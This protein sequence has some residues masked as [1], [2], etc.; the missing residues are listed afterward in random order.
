[1]KKVHILTFHNALNYGGILQCYALYTTI[2]KYNFCDVIDYRS[3]AIED[4]YKVLRLGRTPKQFI[5][6]LILAN[7]TKAKRTKFNGFIHKNILTTKR[8][9]FLSELENYGWSSEDIF[10]V[11]SDQVWNWEITKDDLAFMCS[12][13]PKYL[14]KF[15]YAAS[16]GREIDHE[17]GDVFKSYLNDFSGISVRESSAC[18]ALREFEINCVQSIDPVFLLEKDEWFKVTTSVKNEN[19]PYVLLY[20]LQKS[21]K[22][23]TTAS[24]YAKDKN[25]R[26]V[27]IST[28]IKRE[29]NAEYIEKCGPDEFVRYFLKADAVF[30]NSFHG[31]SFAILFNR[32]FYFAYL[33]DKTNT[34]SRLKDVIDLFQLQ[35]QNIT[36]QATLNEVIDYEKVNGEIRVKR[37]EAIKYLLHSIQ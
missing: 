15:S 23:A 26:L 33:D 7:R 21:N 11:G 29:Y 8:F 30:T 35:T 4:R 20:L 25:L 31:T 6:S 1:M 14:K 10:C 2:N 9:D 22:L 34:N 19:Q 28:G 37:E 13:V 3:K 24:Q 12:F 17:H 27:I 32:I 36:S 5:K 16:V 18:E